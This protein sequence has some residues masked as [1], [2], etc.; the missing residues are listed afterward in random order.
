MGHHLGMA[1][2][3]PEEARERMVA[4]LRELGFG[5]AV[6]EA[7]R[8]VPRHRLVPVFWEV[9]DGPWAPLRQP[10]EHRADDGDLLA[11]ELLHDVERAF[12]TRRPDGDVVTTS[13]SAPRLLAAQAEEL[14][15][16]PGMSILEIG[17]GPGYFAAL[18]AELVGPSGRVVSVEVDEEVAAA[19]RARLADCG[20]EVTV[21][22]ADGDAGAP[23][24][25]PF[26]RIVASVGCTD[27]ARSWL[28]QLS[29]D[30]F[31]LVPLLH[32]ATHPMLAVTPDGEAGVR[33]ASGY[34]AIQG[35]QASVGLWPHARAGVETPRREPLPERLRRA[36]TPASDDRTPFGT[37]LWGLGFWVAV[38][39]QRAAVLA[40]LNDGAGSSAN[41]DTFEW[42]VA[43]GGAAGEELAGD[44]LASATRWA[45]QGA[46]ALPAFRC[47]FVPASGPPAAGVAVRR[48]DHDQLVELP[49]P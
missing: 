46:P 8:A 22:T 1:A 10:V 36:L 49:S 15:L 2:A 28:E 29:P 44:L 9:S 6:L 3:D 11:L 20:C 14:D 26:D 35:R 38:H 5:P 24:H 33:L 45:E 47:R 39:D 25:A 18:L 12:P 43:W 31:A 48:V 4:R 40:A 32:G 21:L 17:T 19:A 13:A 7:F 23:A 37:P 34:V 42:Q 41:L 30:G 16:R 27:V